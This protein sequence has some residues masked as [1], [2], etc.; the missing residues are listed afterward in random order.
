MSGD[1][2][3]E[4]P[5]RPARRRAA[6]AL[7]AALTA[8]LVLG[9]GPDGSGETIPLTGDQPGERLDV[10]LTQ[11]DD[12]SGVGPTPGPYP[13]PDPDPD[14]GEADRLVSVRLRL[15]NTGTAVYQDSPA[16]AAHLLDAE[17]R[18]FTGFNAPTGAGAG[19]GDAFPDTVT[20]RP[21]GAATG[22]ITFRL[23][24]DAE[25]AAVQFALDGGL[26]DDVG[27]WSLP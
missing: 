27:Q 26:A 15:E 16:P 11:V 20:L 7:L 2:P 22:S 13:Y 19:A 21:G 25:P 14:P 4:G 12:P 8:T 6:L 3:G 17:G 5:A 1:R 10:T 23:P 9:A 24:K 18:R